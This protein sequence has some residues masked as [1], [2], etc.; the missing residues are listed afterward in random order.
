MRNYYDLIT[1]HYHF[2]STC[3]WQPT[4]L[5]IFTEIQLSLH[6]FLLFLVYLLIIFSRYQCQYCFSFVPCFRYADQNNS[7]YGGFLRSVYLV[8]LFARTFVLRINFMLFIKWWSSIK[9]R[10]HHICRGKLFT[11][12]WKPSLKVFDFFQIPLISYYSAKP[13][14][15]FFL[16]YIRIEWAFYSQTFFISNTFF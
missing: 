10:G 14:H 7:E 12:H 2:H 15:D 5:F 16:L 1:F 9:W 11:L 13:V 6:M 8:Q 4:I 3:S